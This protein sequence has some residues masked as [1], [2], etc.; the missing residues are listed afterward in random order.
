MA[1]PGLGAVAG[2]RGAQR[3]PAERKAGSMYVRRRLTPTSTPLYMLKSVSV[4]LS[5]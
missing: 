2:G 1:A 4:S 5:E 3:V